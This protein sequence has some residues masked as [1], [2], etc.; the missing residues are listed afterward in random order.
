MGLQECSRKVPDYLSNVIGKLGRKVARYPR[1]FVFCSLIFTVL[2]GTGLKHMVYLTD[3]E[4]LFLPLQAKGYVERDLIES[5]FPL[6]YDQYVP[7]HETR[8]LSQ[9]TVII[10]TKNPGRDSLGNHKGLLEHGKIID[11]AVKKL[12]VKTNQ[13]EILTFED[14]C[15]KTRSSRG[16]TCQENNIIAEYPGLE[17]LT[18]PVY[19]NPFSK[20][21]IMM[22]SVLGNISIIKN[23]KGRKI[24]DASALRLFYTLNGN[25]SSPKVRRNVQAWERMALNFTRKIQQRFKDDRYEVFAINS[26]SLERELIET[27]HSVFDVLHWCVGILSCF[28]TINGLSLTAWKP[29]Q[30]LRYTIRLNT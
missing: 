14:V 2:F 1:W 9:V 24:L 15:A 13:Q 12:T 8:R 26:K 19:Q 17:H 16:E 7:G 27:V 28:I 21:R 6:D 22:P 18:Y 25:S 23:E 29:K 5:Y 20:N 11:D 10:V 3:I 30:L 4:E